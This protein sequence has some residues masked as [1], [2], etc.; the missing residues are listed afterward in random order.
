MRKTLVILLVIEFLAAF[1]LGQVATVRS[2]RLDRA[3]LESQQR[4]TTD[5]R[6]RFERQRRITEL[7]RWGF[8]GV[9]FA[10][11]AGATILVFR[12]MKGAQ[13]GGA[14]GSQPI[15]SETNPT[16]SAAGSRR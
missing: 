13:D 2:S 3:W 14:P 4:P 15:R 10:V 1:T 6:E 16:S 12:A 8:S 7:Q 11:I 9:L 5:T